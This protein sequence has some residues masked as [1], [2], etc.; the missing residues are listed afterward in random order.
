MNKVKNIALWISAVIGA[1]FAIVGIMST[2][3]KKVIE[4]DR[5]QQTI[6]ASKND[7]RQTKKTDSLIISRFSELNSRFNNLS[8]TLKK[9]FEKQNL[10]ISKQVKSDKGL[11]ELY[12]LTGKME[13]AVNYL[14]P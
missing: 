6:I 14:M 8:D 1:Y 7:I 11:V 9:I 12:K 4:K 5:E 2:F 13:D 10:M 3:S